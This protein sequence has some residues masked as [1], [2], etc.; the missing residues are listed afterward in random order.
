[1]DDKT[2][3]DQELDWK[4]TMRKPRFSYR[5]LIFLVILYI[6]INFGASLISRY[7]VSY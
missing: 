5:D 4:W 6:G 7:M 1:M 3:K 2:P